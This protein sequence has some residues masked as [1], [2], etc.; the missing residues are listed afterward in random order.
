MNKYTVYFENEQGDVLFQEVTAR[1]LR[2]A[3]VTA[4]KEIK[5]EGNDYVPIKC[6][7]GTIDSINYNDIR[8]DYVEKAS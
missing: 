3:V 5:C 2:E 6:S 4:T 1:S 7:I 8:S